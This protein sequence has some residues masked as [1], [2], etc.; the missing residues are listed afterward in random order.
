METLQQL[1]ARYF[2]KNEFAP[3]DMVEW[4]SGLKNRRWPEYGEAMI[5]IEMTPGYRRTEDE[6]GPHQLEP[7]DI[8]VARIDPNDGNFDVYTYDS[9]RF[10][11]VK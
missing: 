11:P 5:V 4:K 9:N 1:A 6:G 8:R 2:E 7:C 10:Q 3:G